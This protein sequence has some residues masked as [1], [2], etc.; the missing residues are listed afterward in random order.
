MQLK[1]LTP[2]KYNKKPLQLQWFHIYRQESNYYNLLQT[3]A[4]VTF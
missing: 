1:T 2:N 3:K 4:L